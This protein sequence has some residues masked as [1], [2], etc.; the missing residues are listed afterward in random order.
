MDFW[1]WLMFP[2]AYFYLTIVK[3]TSRELAAKDMTKQ[4]KES[5][6]DFLVVSFSW[7]VLLVLQ[8]KNIGQQNLFQ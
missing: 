8:R 3:Y 5:L 2:Q 6:L 7:H 1:F 4:H